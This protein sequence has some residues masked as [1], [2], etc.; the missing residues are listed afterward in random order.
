MTDQGASR[1][2]EPEDIKVAREGLAESIARRTAA[3]DLLDTAI[4]ALT[5]VRRG[6]PTAQTCYVHEPS[7]CCIVQ[8]AKRV[9]LGE[10]VYQYDPYNYLITS[11]DLPVMSQIVE[12]SPEKPYLGLVLR[13]DQREV[14]QTVV[15]SKPPPLPE[16]QTN[17]AM[18]VGQ[19]TLPLL[20]ALQRLVALLDEPESIPVLAPLVYREIL[21]RLLAGDQ[22]GRLRQIAAAGSR[23]SQIAVAID[24][25][26]A[27]FKEALR[28][29]EAAEQAR[30][31]V[32][33]FHRHFR[34]LTAMSPLQ[35]QKWLR[36]HEAR[37]LLLAGGIDAAG[38]AFAVGYESH[39]QFNREY[40]RLFGAPPLRDIKSLRRLAGD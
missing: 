5:L 11:V 20:D 14:A 31:S 2:V 30:M 34:E 4:P 39:S 3:C 13:L 17:R 22:G 21:F 36:L 24:W 33:T 8:G 9:Y 27:H 15:D 35:Y 28:V 16:R 23:G 26:K 32:S 1:R 7:L 25:L 10:D 12:A 6:E 38:A 19:V 37:R 18:A 29:E 40:S